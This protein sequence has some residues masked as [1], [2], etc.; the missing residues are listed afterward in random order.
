MVGLEGALNLSLSVVLL[1]TLGSFESHENARARTLTLTL[2]RALL[3]ICGQIAEL[4]VKSLSGNG[5]ATE[6]SR[7]KQRI[8]I[9]QR[10]RVAR[11]GAAGRRACV[12]PGHCTANAESS[13]GGYLVALVSLTLHLVVRKPRSA[14][15]MAQRMRWQR[16]G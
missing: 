14:P 6:L 11:G 5:E 1:P 2:H 15:D 16:E 4:T 8:G 7:P 13:A 3:S 12:K 9:N 10:G